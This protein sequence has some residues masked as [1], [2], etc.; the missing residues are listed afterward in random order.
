MSHAKIAAAL[1][2][3]RS[4]LDSP[5]DVAIRA[6]CDRC[7]LS[8]SAVPAQ[9][10][11]GI[12]RR[13]A[14]SWNHARQKGDASEKD[15]HA[16]KAQWIGRRYTDEQ[17]LNDARHAEGAKQ[18]DADANDCQRHPLAHDQAE[19]SSKLGEM[20]NRAISRRC[21][22]WPPAP[23]AARC[24]RRSATNFSPS[25]TSCVTKPV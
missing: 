12:D 20:R 14:T 15:R 10:D 22:R 4:R 24:R 25:T 17:A 3:Y 1:A 16:G 21:D 9:C 11:D 7:V 2:A 13:R 5:S 8:A 18:A 6:R 23:I 19:D